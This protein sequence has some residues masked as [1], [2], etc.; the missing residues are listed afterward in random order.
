MDQNPYQSQDDR[1]PSGPFQPLPEHEQ[2]EPYRK[3]SGLG[4]A[5]FVIGLLAIIAIIVLSM[6][7]VL[8]LADTIQ[9]D[10]TI[11]EEVI[12]SNSEAML[13]G[14]LLFFS[15]LVSLVGLVLGIVSLFMK[16]RRKVFGIIGV[17]LNGLIVFGF[18]ALL[19]LGIALAGI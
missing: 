10:G 4:I 16:N 12:A 19:L 5:S 1:N 2:G 9:P 3:Q 15:I 14:I 13:A 11:P 8:S 17:V 6:T 18:G 7:T